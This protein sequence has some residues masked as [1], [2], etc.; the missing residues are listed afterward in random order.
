[1]LA[2]QASAC[3]RVSCTGSF[4]AATATD[5][6]IPNVGQN[7]ISS[8]CQINGFVA[9]TAFLFQTTLGM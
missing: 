5:W 4:Y 2:A 7:L 6:A 3:C 9:P 1:M 8:Y